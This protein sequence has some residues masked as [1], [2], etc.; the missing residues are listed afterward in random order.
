MAN[1]RQRKKNAKTKQRKGKLFTPKDQFRGMIRIK[2]VDIDPNNKY[3]QELLSLAQFNLYQLQGYLRERIYLDAIDI[4]TL[5]WLAGN[6]FLKICD[7]IRN[8]AR[9]DPNYYTNAVQ[10][11]VSNII[12]DRITKYFA[13]LK[14]SSGRRIVGT[15]LHA[16]KEISNDIQK[17]TKGEHSQANPFVIVYYK[18]MDK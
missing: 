4:D 14:N 7:D 16:Y 10:G 2:G 17:Y 8:W 1:K 18:D 9:Y 3:H 6:Q 13:H 12:S 11:E 5:K 15:I